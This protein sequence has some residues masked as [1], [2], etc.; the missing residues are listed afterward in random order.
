MH[1]VWYL[2]IDMEKLADFLINHEGLIYELR[3]KVKEV[4]LKLG[5]SDLIAV[6]IA[7]VLSQLCKERLILDNNTTLS[8]FLDSKQNDLH[9][10][11]KHEESLA[12]LFSIEMVFDE[13]KT[14]EKENLY[15]L[16]FHKAKEKINFSKEK[17]N[18]DALK[19]ILTVKSI[20]SLMVEL[21]VKNQSLKKHGE[22]LEST[23]EDRTKDLRKAMETADN[24]NKVKGEFLANMSHEIR[25][26]M[27]AIIGMSYLALKTDLNPKQKGY[28]EKVHRSGK[29]LLGL[30]NDILDF[31]KIEA[32]KMDMESVDFHLDDVLDNFTNLVGLKVEERG[33]ELLID[34]K[35]DVPRGLV[36]DPLRI[37][38]IFIN[39]GNNAVKFTE[40]GE[41]IISAK[42]IES[43]NEKVKLQFTVS[44]TGIGMTEEQLSKMFKSFSQADSSTTRKYGGTGLGL[45]ISKKLTELM[46][47]EIW[48][49][50][51]YGKGTSFHFTAELGLSK[52][53]QKQSKMLPDVLNS[54]KILVVDDNQSAREI[55]S[56]LVKMLGFEVESCD[57]GQR[58]IEKI[59][60]A[61]KKAPFDLILLDWKMP[62]MDGIQTAKKIELNDNL[63]DKP[64][65]MMVTAYSKDEVDSL[66]NE[67]NVIVE[68][69]LS[70]PVNPSTLFDS[71]MDAYGH[72]AHV[73]RKSIQEKSHKEHSD[74]LN[75]ARVLLAEDNEMNQEL[76]VE[77]LEDVGIDVT[78]VGNGRAAVDMLEK[79][80][81]DGVLMD[82]QMPIMDG[83]TAT[84]KIRSN[85]KY[86]DLPVIAMTA[87]VMA[88]DLEKAKEAGMN[89]HIGK[90]LDVVE[91]F[92]TMAQWI[93]VLKPPVMKKQKQTAAKVEKETELPTL[94]GVDTSKGL[95]ISGGKIKLYKRLL[96]K[97]LTSQKTF[98]NDFLSSLDDADKTASE[99]MAHTLKGVA[100]NIGAANVQKN[101]ELLEKAC[102]QNKSRKELKTLLDDVVATLEIV[103]TSLEVMESK[104]KKASGENKKSFELKEHVETLDKI[105]NF[106]NLFDTKAVNLTEELLELSTGTE[107]HKKFDEIIEIMRAYE[108]EKAIVI[109]EEIKSKGI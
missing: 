52:E 43:K 93:K 28:V 14:G 63:T 41:I 94:I 27:N 109:I 76:A 39:L 104:V 33:L 34:I 55:L 49:E 31:S 17:I 73:T 86:K 54:L 15:F 16:Q 106:S 108:F 10:E 77:L 46:K 95:K 18:L 22:Q 53:L 62:T 72:N 12:N 30:I 11:F 107:Y 8:V 32:G 9:F 48:V 89:G 84:K 70:K 66:A 78:V 23:V 4:A 71:I 5:Y 64:R 65:V 51:T 74:G 85:K 29:S 99:R 37:G 58:A 101:A 68:R 75:G 50:S 44:D 105:I 13:V 79:T 36:G 20:E 102:Q 80:S 97:F 6:Q 67:S 83:Y 57:S 2:S 87:N 91:M 92:S 59:E 45:A 98:K 3:S 19:E 1:P 103:L 88:Q 82:V 60:K 26:P 42:V 81:F 96:L 47:G 61:D 24:A 21:E 40:K 56:E 35:S 100:G 38:Q 90:P 25:T 7:S 69:T